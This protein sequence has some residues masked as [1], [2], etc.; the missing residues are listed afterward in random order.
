MAKLFLLNQ[1]PD[2][3][4]GKVGQFPP[5]QIPDFAR[6]EFILLKPSNRVFCELHTALFFI[7]FLRGSGLHESIILAISSYLS[8]SPNSRF[9]ERGSVAWI[10]GST[11][12]IGED[13]ACNVSIL[14]ARY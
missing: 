2:N 14:L 10:L 9:C 12:D 6:M 3:H 13:V 7:V 5:M 8:P 11:P 1:T 4:N